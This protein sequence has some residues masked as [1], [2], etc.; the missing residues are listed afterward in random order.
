LSAI[1]TIVPAVQGEVDIV[2]AK[3]SLKEHAPLA[4]WGG[5]ERARRGERAGVDRPL[6]PLPGPSSLSLSLSL[7]RSLSPFLSLHSKYSA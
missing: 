2:L 5:E 6:F 7:S 3:F 4:S 1:V